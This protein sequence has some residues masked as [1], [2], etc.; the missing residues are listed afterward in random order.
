MPLIWEEPLQDSFFSISRASTMDY[1]E[2]VYG[3]RL[4]SFPDPLA[5]AC[6]IDPSS[7]T[8]SRK[9]ESRNNTRSE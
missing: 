8:E 9:N 7:V 2:S 4:I 6:V 5:M 1:K 3:K